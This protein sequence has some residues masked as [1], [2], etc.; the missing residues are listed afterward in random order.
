M[1]KG[2]DGLCRLVSS[3]HTG[4]DSTA[5]GNAQR[6]LAN[7]S[8]LLAD[9]SRASIAE[10]KAQWW[11]TE[12]PN[13]LQWSIDI[14]TIETTY[15]D[16]TTDNILQRAMGVKNAGVK[17]ATDVGK[18][19]KDYDVA[20]AAAREEYISKLMTIA[21]SIGDTLLDAERDKE[22][23]LADA[24]LQKQLTG[25]ESAY[26]SAVQAANDAYTNTTTSAEASRKSQEQTARSTM[27]T[28]LSDELKNKEAGIAAAEREYDQTV[29]SLDA[30]YGSESS[31]GDTGVEGATRRSAIKTRDAQYYAARDTSWANT[32]SGS[33]TLGTSP[34]TVKAITAANSQAAH[35]VSR[36]NAQAA[37][38]AAM[39]D[40]IEDWQDATSTSTLTKLAAQANGSETF[41]N[42]VS[43]AFGDW[44]E[45]LGNYSTYLPD[46][47]VLTENAT[48]SF[49]P[50]EAMVQSPNI[51]IPGGPDDFGNGSSRPGELPG[52]PSPKKRSWLTGEG[53]WLSSPDDPTT[54]DRTWWQFGGEMARTAFELTP[55]W[56]FNETVQDLNEHLDRPIFVNEMAHAIDGSTHN[57]FN[58]FSFGASDYVGATDSERFHYDSSGNATVFYYQSGLFTVSREALLLAGTMSVRA[59]LLSA[60]GFWAGSPYARVLWSN[61]GP[62]NLQMILRAEIAYHAAQTVRGALT[63]PGD[64][65]AVYN[66]P[67]SLQAW[68][69]LGTNTAITA[70]NIFGLKVAAGSKIQGFDKLTKQDTITMLRGMSHEEYFKLVQS[71]TL[72][73]HSMRTKTNVPNTVLRRL[74]HT[75][76]STTPPSPNVST[77]RIPLIANYFTRRSGGVVAQFE[78]PRSA[79]QKSAN[80]FEYEFLIEGGTLVSNVR[81]L[82]SSYRAGWWTYAAWGL[83][84]TGVT[85]GVG[86]AAVFA[87]KYG[88]EW[89]F[90]E[91]Q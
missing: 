66:D 2:F 1:K 11:Q 86:G 49:S 76:T 41:N 82:N 24:E 4:G 34:W 72:V 73:S 59:A 3:T 28:K 44:E 64:A 27:N 36:A 58:V 26:S 52:R 35:S 38:D 22:I 90:G 6:G 32:L 54:E 53:T 15:T 91:Q 78:V 57:I 68:W 81:L 14:G 40:A 10:L 67:T 12:T 71:Q 80:V 83:E 51:P 13:Y 31:N 70:L 37:H 77:T 84:S 87:G 45:F 29:A 16:D 48:V 56:Q 20:T 89:L 8:S 55:G 5:R 21:K 79:L 43:S 60:K 69:G 65:Q 7:A 62:R 63:L 46:E 75:F 25:N 88:Y 42:A 17:Y 9:A 30:Q 50:E 19:I 47:M 85:L 61:L 74:W 39:L 18:S 33:T 23:A